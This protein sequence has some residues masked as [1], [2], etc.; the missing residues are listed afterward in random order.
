MD[1][2]QAI[3]DRLNS[4]GAE[5]IVCVYDENSHTDHRW[6]TGHEL[7]RENYKLIL[8]ELLKNKRLGVI[9]KPKTAYTLRERLG[10]VNELLQDAEETGRCLV[11]ENVSRTTT[12]TSPIIAAM[13][14]DLC[15]HAHLCAGTAALEAY[16]AGTP[17][18]LIDREG[19]PKSK[20]YELP[21]GK[22]RF[23]DWPETINAMNAFFDK[24][25]DKDLGNWKDF[26]NELEPYKDGLGAKRMGFFLERLRIELSR[27][28]SKNEAIDSA[29]QS[30][31][32]IWGSD[33]VICSKT[34][35]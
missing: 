13:A 11:M 25:S 28:K 34:L 31:K 33:K 29:A 17:T 20:F 6:H 18:F 32:E 19:F 2:A 21:E 3:R 22:V 14:S 10:E 23:K 27:R 8:R 4:N 35:T 5:N 26:I 7:Q 9:F 24:D 30:F 12:I 1:K 16:L 15:I